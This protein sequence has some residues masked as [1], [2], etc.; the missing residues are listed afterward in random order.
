[1]STWIWTFCPTCTCGRLRGL[2]F[3]SLPCPSCLC[4]KQEPAEHHSW[5]SKLWIVSLLS[6][7]SIIHQA[8][9]SGTKSFSFPSFDPLWKELGTGLCCLRSLLMCCPFPQCILR[10]HCLLP[11]HQLQQVP[12]ASHVPVNLSCDVPA[13]QWLDLHLLSRSSSYCPAPSVP[14]RNGATHQFS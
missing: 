4:G 6:P 5:R 3:Q 12:F 8:G 10:Y 11:S 1:M 7:Q 9:P 14:S 2:S 13:L